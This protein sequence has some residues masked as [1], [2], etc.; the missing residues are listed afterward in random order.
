MD[1]LVR[2]ILIYYLT[3]NTKYSTMYTLKKPHYIQFDCPGFRN[4]E[5]LAWSSITVGS[6]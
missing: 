1:K 6:V 4:L 2:Y 3:A 5:N